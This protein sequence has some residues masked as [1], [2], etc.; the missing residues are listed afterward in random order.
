MLQEWKGLG[1]DVLRFPPKLR[2]NRSLDSRVMSSRARNAGCSQ[3]EGG[4]DGVPEDRVNL[5]RAARHAALTCCAARHAALN[6]SA[7]GQ[8]DC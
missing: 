5:Q 1:P 2:T 7:L 8:A 4:E 6:G 3:G